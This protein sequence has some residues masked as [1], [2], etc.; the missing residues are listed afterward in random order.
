M[1][2]WQK[3]G[4]KLSAKEKEWAYKQWCIGYTQMQIAEALHVCDKT[5]SRALKDR[6]RIRPIL[7]YEEDNDAN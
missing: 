2:I 7:K 5:I 4:G 3:G 1:S 6:P